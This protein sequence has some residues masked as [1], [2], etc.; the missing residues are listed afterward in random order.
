MSPDKTWERSVRQSQQWWIVCQI[1]AWSMI[2]IMIPG[3]PQCCSVTSSEIVVSV[4]C[5]VIMDAHP[6]FHVLLLLWISSQLRD[7]KFPII[8]KAIWCPSC[9][10]MTR[11]A[12]TIC[13]FEV[14]RDMIT[15]MSTW[16]RSR[17][18]W[19]LVISQC[20]HLLRYVEWPLCY[21]NSCY[22]PFA[23]SAW[24]SYIDG[25]C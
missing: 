19:Q 23:R 15:A 21:S 25:P 16:E 13:R 2:T 12:N 11:L 5:T 6:W 14:A 20:V 22:D 1:V 24:K 9:H 10:P 7:R 17:T 3:S 4:N 18:N 8:Q